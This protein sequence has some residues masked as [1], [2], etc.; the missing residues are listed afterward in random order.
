MG[1]RLSEGERCWVQGEAVTYRKIPEQASG[2]HLPWSPKVPHLY[3]S[4]SG[5]DWRQEAFWAQ[6]RET[7]KAGE[8]SEVRLPDLRWFVGNLH[9]IC[10]LGS[11]PP[12]TRR[13]EEKGAACTDAGD[14]FELFLSAPFPYFL[15]SL[16]ILLR[17]NKSSAP[18]SSPS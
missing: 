11:L 4:C 12:V 6:E 1:V 7:R 13:L 15:L 5:R 14:G 18:S 2:P 9:L 3:G 16:S 17:H 8:A 10:T